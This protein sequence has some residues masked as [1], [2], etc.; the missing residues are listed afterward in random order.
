MF[1]YDKNQVPY[2]NVTM[3][4][5]VKILGILGHWSNMAHIGIFL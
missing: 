5:K 1:K 4:Q 3:F 2:C